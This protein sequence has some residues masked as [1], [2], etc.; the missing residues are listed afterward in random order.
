MVHDHELCYNIPMSEVEQ[1]ATPENNTALPPEGEAAFAE[2]Q[3]I[4]AVLRGAGFRVK[5]YILDRANFVR[6]WNSAELKDIYMSI[7]QPLVSDGG[8]GIRVLFR[9][10]HWLVS[11]TNSY[12][13]P[14]NETR[15]QI[16]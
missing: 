16:S 4:A 14:T 1:A 6:M 8:D 3:K 7:S 13:K 10:G 2:L 12:E 15:V 5:E 9:N 11:Y